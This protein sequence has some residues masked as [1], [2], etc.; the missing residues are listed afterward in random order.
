MVRLNEIS[1]YPLPKHPNP[2]KARMLHSTIIT[3]SPNNNLI[4]LSP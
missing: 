2:I 3:H 4:R 1:A